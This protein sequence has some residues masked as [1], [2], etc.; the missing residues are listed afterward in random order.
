M[1]V[2][3]KQWDHGW[4]LHVDGVGVTQVRTLATAVQQVVDFVET[5][6][7]DN[8]WPAVERDLIEIVPELPDDVVGKAV[9]ARMMLHDAEVAMTE[10]AAASREVARALREDCGLSVT[11]TAFIMGVSR[12]RV[13]QLT[14]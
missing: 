9:G 8:A 11:D 2:I 14:S 1:K 10:A 3:A 5:M 6:D 4:E 12:G 7:G 13:S